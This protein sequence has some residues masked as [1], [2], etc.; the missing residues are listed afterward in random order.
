M[1][2]RGDRGEGHARRP[3]GRS[4]SFGGH[5]GG[6]VGGAGK[7]AGG[8]SGGQPPLSSNRSFRKP[9]N[10]HGG[11]QRVVNQPDTTGFQPAP[12]PGPLQTPPRPPA[13]QNAPVHVPVS[14][15]RPQ[16]HD[17][18]GLQAPS[19]SPASENPTYIPL[20]KNIPRA[21][22]KA[23]PK[24]SNAP[25]PQGAPKGLVHFSF[26]TLEIVYMR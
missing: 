23:P 24:S 8:P 19:M 26:C 7:G 14:A 9:G 3:G 11:H 20:P 25:A 21:G 1:S 6:G 22:P 18:P 17:S 5:R 2:Q 13:P 12:A 15:P 10:G 4:N 16:H